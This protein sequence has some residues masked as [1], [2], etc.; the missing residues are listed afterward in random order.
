VTASQ[1]PWAGAK[2]LGLDHFK[3]LTPA[4][5]QTAEVKALTEM[6][7]QRIASTLSSANPLRASCTLVSSGIVPAGINE[8]EDDLFRFRGQNG[9]LRMRILAERDFGAMLCELTLGGAGIETGEEESA[10]PVTKL[11]RKLK[12]M[13][14]RQFAQSAA[15]AVAETL[16]HPLEHDPGF[17][18]AESKWPQPLRFLE[19]KMLINAFSYG[20]EVAL[21]ILASDLEQLIRLNGAKGSDSRSAGSAMASCAFTLS[22]LLPPAAVSLTD[23]IAMKPGTLL[24]LPLNP[25][26]R[27]ILTCGSIPVFQAQHRRTPG[28]LEVTLHPLAGNAETVEENDRGM[29]Q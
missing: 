11:E 9:E 28:R 1:N 19:Y 27:M 2:A 16:E 17:V 23:I 18:P 3:A 25:A 20:C 29:I 22:A 21:Q 6:V 10:R 7:P 14:L 8:R 24:Q 26:E 12:T 13:I 15:S 4:L 5:A